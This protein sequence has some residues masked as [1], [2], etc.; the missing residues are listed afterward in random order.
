MSNTGGIN[1]PAGAHLMVCVGMTLDGGALIVPIVSRH[2]YSDTACLINVGD[3]PFITRES[4]AS[5]DFF[6][7][8]SLVAINKDIEKGVVKTRAAVSAELLVRL[9]IGIVTSDELAPWAYE[10]C[11]G[12]ELKT[13]LIK[14]GHM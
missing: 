8:I 2:E 13:W 12:D 9:Q 11:K 4:C 1:N 10:E 14:K 3:H 6:R 7:K 5:Y